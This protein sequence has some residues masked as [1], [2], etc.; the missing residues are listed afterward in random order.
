MHTRMH[1]HPPTQGKPIGISEM[2]DNP[3][4][5]Y[6]YGCLCLF[7]ISLLL[8]FL[9][10]SPALSF[11]TFT[12]SLSLFPFFSPSLSFSFLFSSFI[13]LNKIPTARVEPVVFICTEWN[14]NKKQ[15]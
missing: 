11:F 10:Q 2:F 5:F 12:F 14:N 4:D 7:S 13:T 9:S 3:T 8:L 15:H 6:V 1:T